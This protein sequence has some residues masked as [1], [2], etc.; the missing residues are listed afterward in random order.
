LLFQDFTPREM[1]D[2]QVTL[3][4]AADVVRMVLTQGVE[5]AVSQANPSTSK[6]SAPS[7]AAAPKTQTGPVQQQQQQQQPK[8]PS[9]SPQQQQQQQQQAKAAPA[10]TVVAAVSST[11]V[12]S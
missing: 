3:H 7:K 2:M 12:R 9:A 8:Q 10:S 5:K 11:P 1:E 4:Q 6:P